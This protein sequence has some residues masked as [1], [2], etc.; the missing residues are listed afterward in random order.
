M[1]IL[2]SMKTI[3]ILNRI[4]T[5]IVLTIVYNF[6]V[7]LFTFLDRYV[8]KFGWLSEKQIIIIELFDE[9]VFVYL[10][11]LIVSVPLVISN[12]FLL[13]YLP[14]K[15]LLFIVL[16]ITGL[17]ITAL[18]NLVFLKIGYGYIFTEFIPYCILSQI[19]FFAV[20]NRWR[21][22]VARAYDNK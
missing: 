7:S 19:I 14:N 10:Y 16:L 13:N 20:T 5:F 22:L 4:K 21:E 18:I 2:F 9:F 15:R 8:D 11:G 1:L 3:T 6:L 17:L 12:L